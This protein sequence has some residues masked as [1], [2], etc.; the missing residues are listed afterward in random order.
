MIL[1]PFDD[2]ILNIKDGIIHLQVIRLL[3]GHLHL[4]LKLLPLE[5]NIR[6]HYERFFQKTKKKR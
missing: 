4:L 3:L 1:D 6:V 5:D 2:Q